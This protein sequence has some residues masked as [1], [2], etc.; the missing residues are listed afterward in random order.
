MEFRLLGPLE[1]ADGDGVVRL[2][3]GRQRSVLVLLLLHRNEAVSSDRLIDALWGQRPPPTAAKVL[4]NHVGQL[5]RALGDRDGARL[6]TRGRGYAVRVEAGELDVER[7]EQLVREGRDALSRDEP[8]VAATRLRE[9]LALWRGPALADVAY[10]SFA[11]PEIARLEEHRL[12]AVE[13]G[14]EAELALGR[15]ADVIG[16][17]E[18]LVAEHPLR[19]HLR[20][21]LMLALYRSGRQAD[22]LEVFR[23]ARHALVEGLGLEP[24]PAL[25]ELEA[26]ILEQSPELSVPRRAQPRGRREHTAPT[27][28]QATSRTAVRRG[29]PVVLAV[30]GAIMLLLAAVLAGRSEQG[31]QASRR[32]PI[33]D[34]TPNSLVRLGTGDGRPQVAVP[35]GGRPVDVVAAEGSVWIAT[36]DP[37]ALVEVAVETTPVARPVA[38]PI[39]PRALAVDEKTVW[40]VDRERGRLLGLRRGYLDV[41]V[42]E[43]YR[44]R[45]APAVVRSGRGPSEPTGVAVGAGAVWIVDGDRRVVRY[46]PQSRTV[47]SVPTRMVVDSVVAAGGAIW[48]ASSASAAV[49]R[50]DPR[51]SRVTDP[52]PLGRRG[53]APPAPVALAA[54]GADLW[55]LNAN[56]ASLTRIDARRAGI[57]ATV[58]VGLDRAPSDIAAAG[59]SV[60]VANGD[61]SVNRVTGGAPAGS[62]DVGEALEHVAV[63]GDHL[64][65]TTAA[66]DQHVAGGAG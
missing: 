37:D 56:T 47:T 40:L 45:R 1:V 9:G 41:A 17:L 48:A 10:E 53:I 5:R 12:V 51:G 15:H 35:L 46:D 32:P 64:W 2:A 20:G 21:Q 25:R 60:W 39:R 57:V 63:L 42:N 33:L 49:L 58:L 54:E 13:Q 18:A 59:G 11:Q 23:N 19:E 26:Q 7:F 66:V 16:E 50:I 6:Q 36:V 44:R 61:G 65:V 34:L 62:F 55:T 4:Q 52:V 8:D 27:V 43:R 14:I 30:A 29:L 31:S 28:P 3:E 38:L 24:S 22:A